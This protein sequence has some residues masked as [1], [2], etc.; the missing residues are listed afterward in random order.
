MIL[1]LLQYLMRHA[2]AAVSPKRAYD[3]KWRFGMKYKGY[4]LKLFAIVST[5]RFF[6][7]SAAD[8]SCQL[9]PGGGYDGP[10][11]KKG[12][13]RSCVHQCKSARKRKNE[14]S[15]FEDYVKGV[16]AGEMPSSLR[17]RH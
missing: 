8:G 12:P 5:M 9:L 3:R 11:M 2:L 10:S 17:W 16:V 1:P 13:L 4:L 7:G 6:A 14:A 15:T